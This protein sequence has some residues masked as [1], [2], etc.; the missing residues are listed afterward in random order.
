M[1]HCWFYFPSVTCNFFITKESTAF[2]CLTWKSAACGHSRAFGSSSHV[3]FKFSTITP[4]NSVSVSVYLYIFICI[5]SCILIC[6]CIDVSVH[7][8]DRSEPPSPG[9]IWCQPDDRGGKREK[10]IHPQSILCIVYTVFSVHY[11]NP[12]E[13]Y[14]S[15]FLMDIYLSSKSK[16]FLQLIIYLF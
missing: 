15:I 8:C 16:F 11:T 6:I 2:G 7:L 14:L 4:T 5:C 13:I 12:L 9:P 1:S 3:I 10:T